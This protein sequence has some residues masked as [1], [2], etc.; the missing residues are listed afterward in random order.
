MSVKTD[1]GF[2]GAKENL[3]CYYGQEYETHIDCRGR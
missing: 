1:N 3:S 2:S